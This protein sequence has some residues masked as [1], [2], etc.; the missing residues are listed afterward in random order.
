[1]VE[2]V[3]Q[4]FN[5]KNNEDVNF[6]WHSE[7]FRAFGIDWTLEVKTSTNVGCNE[8]IKYVEVI[9]YAEGDFSKE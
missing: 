5:R 9:L 7:T 1:M 8:A 4:T 6:C 2:N 3:S